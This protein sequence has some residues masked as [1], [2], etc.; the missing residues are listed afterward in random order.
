MDFKNESHRQNSTSSNIVNYIY[1]RQNFQKVVFEFK[2]IKK[3]VNI[4]YCIRHTCIG[5][6][7]LYVCMYKVYKCYT[8]YE[9]NLIRYSDSLNHIIT[10]RTYRIGNDYKGEKT[11]V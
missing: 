9:Y 11:N 3:N 7:L 10:R 6:L 2:R 1:T 4:I 8:L 5:G